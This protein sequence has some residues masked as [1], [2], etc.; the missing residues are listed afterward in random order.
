MY[1]NLN[2]GCWSALRDNLLLSLSALFSSVDPAVA[3]AI[4]CQVVTFAT[5]KPRFFHSNAF[6]SLDWTLKQ[7]WKIGDK[8]SCPLLEWSLSNIEP[9]SRENTW[10]ICVCVR[11]CFFESRNS[12]ICQQ[13]SGTFFQ[14]PSPLFGCRASVTLELVSRVKNSLK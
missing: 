1:I 11:E 3:Y 7:T 8:F 5:N 10:N 2:R 13:W 6:H 14:C 12:E 9:C 4:H